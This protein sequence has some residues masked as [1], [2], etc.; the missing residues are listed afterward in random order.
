VDNS[1][2]RKFLGF[3]FTTGKEPNRI[4]VHESRVKRFKPKF[5]TKKLKPLTQNT[6]MTIT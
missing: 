5:T 1:W 2:N 6:G 3:T 4:A